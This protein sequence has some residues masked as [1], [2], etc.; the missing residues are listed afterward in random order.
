MHI[1][2][3]ICKLNKGDRFWDKI[4][5]WDVSMAYICFNEY[6]ELSNEWKITTDNIESKPDRLVICAIND[7]VGDLQYI[8]AWD[9][10]SYLEDLFIKGCQFM[11]RFTEEMHSIFWEKWYE[12]HPFQTNEIQEKK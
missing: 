5:C 4:H 12:K 1:E 6:S 3:E 2:Y 7:E 8:V 9:H 10:P 11:P